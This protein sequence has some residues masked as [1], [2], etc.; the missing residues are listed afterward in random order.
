MVASKKSVSSLFEQYV[1]T[2]PSPQN[3]VDSVPGWTCAFPPE[4]PVKAGPLPLYADDR[5]GWML[6][7][8]GTLEGRSVLELGPLEGSHT[9]MIERAGAARIDAVEANKLA[10]LRCLVFK[11]LVALQRARFHLGN[12]ITWLGQPDLHYDLIVASGVL[13]H[14]RDPLGFLERAAAAT[15]ALFLWTHYMSETA[16][17]PTDIR[18]GVFRD[19]VERR[20][21]HGV[22]VRLYPRS[23]HR[24]EENASFCGG[25]YDDHR[26]IE[27]DDL[28]AVLRALGFD[29][30]Q[31]AHE[32]A[33]HP[34][35]PSFSV[36]ARRSQA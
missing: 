9:Y 15:D 25:L 5:I 6:E 23:Y 2:M 27:R 34:N 36:L 18:R 24:A 22:N 33:D 32:Q 13:Y 26:W 29:T 20:S 30:L 7:Q 12:F 28:L 11:E 10:Y 17:P 35:G 3:A 16:M 21:F 14:L 4:M 1:D 8:Y 31:I 19:G